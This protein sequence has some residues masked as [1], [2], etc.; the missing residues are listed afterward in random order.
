M[1]Q[2][3]FESPILYQAALSSFSRT[4]ADQDNG[5]GLRQALPE[6]GRGYCP[7]L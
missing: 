7:A 2:P 5:L 4:L 6:A 1:K 3:S